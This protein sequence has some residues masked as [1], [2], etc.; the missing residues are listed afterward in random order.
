MIHNYSS[1]SQIAN[2][3]NRSDIPKVTKDILSVGLNQFFSVAFF[4]SIYQEDFDLLETL[5]HVSK[6]HNFVL[7]MEYQVYIVDFL[8][9]SNRVDI[10]QRYVVRDD[11]SLISDENLTIRLIRSFYGNLSKE[12]LKKLLENVSYHG[13]R[14]L[15]K[16][17]N[18]KGY[19]LLVNNSSTAYFEK[20]VKSKY[21]NEIFQV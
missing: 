1:S 18:R 14:N 4:S 19:M 10:L 2:L 12:T 17:L 6:I 5:L 9:S 11:I 8:E 16:D 3:H 21:G 13:I 20:Y 7:T 15:I